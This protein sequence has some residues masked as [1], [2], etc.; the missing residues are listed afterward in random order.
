MPI[1][2]ALRITVLNFVLIKMPE[3]VLTK[4]ILVPAPR[5]LKFKYPPLVDAYTEYEGMP[6]FV[7]AITGTVIVV[8]IK[9]P[10]VV[11]TK[12]ILV[13]APRVLKFK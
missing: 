8:L 2:V 5:V 6:I 4:E 11:F 9:I 12:E 3:V 1:F 13:P 7:A 10:E